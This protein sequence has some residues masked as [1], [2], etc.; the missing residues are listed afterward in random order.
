MIYLTGLLIFLV[1]LFSEAFFAGAEIALVAADENQLKKQ[2]KKSL[3]AKIALK[4]LKKPEWLLTTT[5]LGLNLSVIG[6]SVVTTKFLLKVSPEFGG[7]LAVFGLP[8]L[9]LLFGQM[10]PKSIAQQKADTMAPKVAPLVYLVSRFMYPLVWLVANLI[11][12]VTKEEGKKLPSITREEI[13]ILVSSEETLDPR[14]KLLISRLIDFSKKT[15]TQV[16][17]PLVRVKAVEK[18]QPLK[19]ALKLFVETGF[20]RIL[21]YRKHPDRLIGVLIA[22]DVLGVKEMERP[23]SRFMREVLYVPEFKLAAEL[24]GEMQKMGQ[25]LAVVVNEYGQAVGIITIEDLVEEVLGEFWDEFDQKLIPYVKLA[26]NHFLVKAWMEIEQANEELGLN[27]PPGDY[28]TIGG[29]VL[30]IAGRIPKPG[31]I[32]EYQNLKIQVRRASKTA[33]DELEIWVKSK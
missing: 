29:F 32:I 33:L 31:E 18:S 13:R 15:A 7:I 12:L 17:I 10:I 8:P 5:L 24:L 30:K 16:M 27:I 28:E 25:T 11:S 9:M 26:E 21:V 3:G 4:L 1:L 22:L 14:E 19:E 20:S 6:N 23:V 2:A